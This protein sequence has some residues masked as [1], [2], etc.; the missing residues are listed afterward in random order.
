[1][2][3]QIALFLLIFLVIDAVWISQI[4]GPIM[5]SQLADLLAAEV[6]WLAALT[7]YLLYGAAYWYLI[8]A[9]HQR[10]RSATIELVKRSFAFG[11]ICY[12]TYD[13]TSL[14]VL[15]DYTWTI[16]VMDML[17]GGALTAVSGTLTHQLTNS[18]LAKT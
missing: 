5:Q 9:P 4:I 10:Q 18:G 13:L 16:A 17:W 7:F 3:K 1:M 12:A 11:L 14:S 6:N 2:L 15:R 8:L